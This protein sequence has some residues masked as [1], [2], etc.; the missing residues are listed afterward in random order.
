MP[1]PNRSE[2]AS[3][4]STN[5]DNLHRTVLVNRKVIKL[6]GR[7]GDVRGNKQLRMKIER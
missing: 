7:H 1:V 5:A 3:E 4:A 2:D 6:G